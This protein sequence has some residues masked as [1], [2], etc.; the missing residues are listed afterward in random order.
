MKAIKISSFGDASVLKL[1]DTEPKPTPGEG[2]VLVR[3]RAA[4]VN[5]VDIY[6]RRGTYPL[7]LPFIPGLEASGVIEAIGEKVLDFRVGDRVAYTGH[8]GSYSEYAAIDAERLIKLPRALSF[9]QGA[10]F[11]LQGMAAHFLIHDFRKPGPGDTVLVHAAAGGSGAPSG[12]VGQ[13]PRRHGNRDGID[14][15]KGYR[16]RRACVTLAHDLV[17]KCLSLGLQQNTPRSRL[18]TKPSPPPPDY[19]M[20]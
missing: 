15:R 16:G 9:E 13:T 2:Q 10:A 18:L 3:I 12:S 6:H 7:K 1:T 4:G 20:P 8:L 5:F 11:L 14:G 19:R 17:N